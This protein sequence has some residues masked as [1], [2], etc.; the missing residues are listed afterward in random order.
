M[1]TSTKKADASRANAQHSTGPVTPEGKQ[2][3]S[4]NALRHGLTSTR[5]LLPGESA[6][7]FE[8]LRLSILERYNPADEYELHLATNI[9]VTMWR[10]DRMYA[11]ETELFAGYM[12]VD[13][14]E[15]L[16]RVAGLFATRRSHDHLTLMNRYKIGPA[17]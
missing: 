8:A 11:I 7:E 2:R 15:H 5:V 6:E 10:R 13:G 9:A 17:K 3:S 14:A 1:P 16:S 4:A 12:N